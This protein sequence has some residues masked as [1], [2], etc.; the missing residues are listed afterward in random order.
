MS[1][2]IDWASVSNDYYAS[3][4]ARMQTG[5][6][7]TAQ[8]DDASIMT[9]SQTTGSTNSCTDGK[10]D[11]KIGLFS[12]IGNMF[13]GAAKGIINGVKGMFTNKDG[14]FSILKTLGT[15]ALGATCIAFPAAGLVLCGIGAVAG[16]VKLGTGVYK[17]FNA[18]TDAEAKDA[19]EQV[20]DGGLTLAG[21]II[22]AKASYG[23][24]KSSSTAGLQG[25]DDAAATEAIAQGKTSAMSQL[26]SDASVTQKLA[27]LG[28]DAVSSTK[29]NFNNIKAGVTQIRTAHKENKAQIDE[30]EN[31]IAKQ[32]NVLD[33]AKKANNADDIKAAED[34][35]K[36]A[37][38]ALKQYK[39]ENTALGK[40]GQKLKNLKDTQKQYK[41]AKKDYK[42]AK[43]ILKEATEQGDEGTISRANEI[44][45]IRE[46]QLA[47]AKA[48]TP[49]GKL[50]S[51]FSETNIGEALKTAKANIKKDGIVNTVKGLKKVPEGTYTNILKAIPEDAKAIISA[52][53]SDSGKY[54]KLVQQYGYENVLSALE[55]FMALRLADESV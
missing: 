14:K 19:W 40:A 51:K 45:E 10:D 8:Q 50:S 7:R 34:G 48:E 31:T 46:G 41:T 12:A 3:R 42:E 44:L 26:E 22:G 4:I 32:Q 24:M 25:L 29:N 2:G 6:Y 30:L 18:K 33:E 43:N 54:S 37:Q 28:K 20:G 27:A 36:N 55:T 47:Q 13:Q 9:S 11:G 17:V 49:L 53:K 1:T 52:L 39:A 35:L 5:T 16:G 38:E 21:S 23:A 15:V